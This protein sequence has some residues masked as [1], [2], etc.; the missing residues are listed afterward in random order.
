M[1]APTVLPDTFPQAVA[2]LSAPTP[3]PELVREELSPP[4][5][6]AA[7]GH[8]IGGSA[9]RRGEGVATG[10][11]VLLYNPAGHDAWEGNLRLVSYVTA[12]IETE[13]AI[14][15][16]LATVGWSWLT[17]ALDERGTEY[18]AIAG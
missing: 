10:R 15:P 9:S 12:E 1:A 6:R 18:T 2:S 11:L 17:D 4:Q 13:L 14:G 7:L 8:G 5:K 3:R 16:L